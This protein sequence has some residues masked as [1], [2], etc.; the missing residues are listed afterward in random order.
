MLFGVEAS[1][2]FQ[3]LEREEAVRL[4]GREAYR[5]AILLH[6]HCVGKKR[7][8]PARPVR[9]FLQVCRLLL[10]PFQFPDVVGLHCGKFPALLSLRGKV[11]T[12]L[13]LFCTIYA[14]LFSE[15]GFSL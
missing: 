7:E 6:A 13:D 12:F 9:P 1:V 4:F 14:P 8:P 3:R 2:V 5:M 10:F 11:V 15:S